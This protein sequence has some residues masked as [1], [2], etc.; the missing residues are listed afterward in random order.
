MC[1]QDRNPLVGN[2]GLRALFAPPQPV[3][4]LPGKRSGKFCSLD[5]KSG[6]LNVLPQQ[7][8][9]KILGQNRRKPCAISKHWP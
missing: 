7:Y 3:F 2:P 1:Q 5:R 9:T 6:V 4:V 8:A